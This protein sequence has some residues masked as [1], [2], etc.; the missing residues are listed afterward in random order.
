MEIRQALTEDAD[1]ICAVLRRSIN[2]QCSGGWLANKSREV[3]VCAGNRM[4]VAEDNSRIAAVGLVSG[5]GEVL[6]NYVAPEC[7]FRGLSK[8]MLA[9]L[10]RCVRANGLSR[11]VLESTETAQRFYL[12]RGYA[13]QRESVA[14]VFAPIK[15]R[16]NCKSESRQAAA[17]HSA[18]LKSSSRTH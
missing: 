8:A 10:E 4:L 2:M 18:I 15:W 7:R 5:E 11:C 16:R 17:T 12:S 1:A 14:T 13:V 3:Q 9:A 6:L